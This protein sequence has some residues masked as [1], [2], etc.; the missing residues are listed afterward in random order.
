MSSHSLEKERQARMMSE[1][2]LDD[3]ERVIF[4][5]TALFRQ[6]A[7]SPT[8][9]LLEDDESVSPV[10]KDPIDGKRERLESAVNEMEDTIS[11]FKNVLDNTERGRS[12][13]P[14]M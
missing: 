7:M 12:F 8:G 9:S 11:S 5:L 2:R 6:S 3:L 14:T 4:S 13:A 10:D 1:K